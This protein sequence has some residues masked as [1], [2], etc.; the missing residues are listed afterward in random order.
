MEV[1]SILLNRILS[2]AAK[3]QA[4]DLHLTVGSSP[5]LR[6]D[7]QLITMTKEEIITSEIL[8]K[9]I[10][11]FVNQDEMIKLKQDKEIILAKTL[12]NNFRF[13]I[14][15]FYQK[16]L[17]ALS[18]H[19]ISGVIKS[20]DELNIPPVL[21]NFLTLNSGLL[22]IAGPYG[23]GKTTTAS[24]FIEEVNKAHSKRIITIENPIEALFISKK[25]IILQ[26]QIGRDVKTVA[27]ALDHCLAEDVDLVYVSEIKDEQEFI[28][29]LP[30]I[31]E[32]S[33][34]N[35]LVILEINA[36]RSIRALEKILGALEKKLS[37]EAARYNLADILLA[38]IAQRLLPHRGGGL[39]LAAEVLLNNSAVKSLIREGK[40]YQLESIMQTSRK[41]GMISLDK[42]FDNLIEAGEIKREDIA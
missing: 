14:N 35:C 33:A 22:I 17:P 41:E 12:A 20:L 27:Q 29:A 15:I 8:N 3:K 23:S 13:R 38:V 9:I 7:G 32:L 34:G 24:S 39:I 21:N 16:D 36:D 40:I 1:P 42:A 25:S 26:R 19:Y 18:F 11:S 30:V 31:L 6:V 28:L 37:I 5:I 2:E 10:E 4:T